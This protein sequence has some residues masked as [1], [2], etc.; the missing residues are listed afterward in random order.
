MRRQ[1]RPVRKL[2][3]SRVPKGAAQ[4]KGEHASV[5]GAEGD[6]DVLEEITGGGR[7]EAATLKEEEV[8]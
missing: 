1:R 8:A 4:P 6:R 3:I 2:P 7:T 5:S